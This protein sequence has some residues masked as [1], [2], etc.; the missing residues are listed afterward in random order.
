VVVNSELRLRPPKR[1]PPDTGG[2]QTLQ[3]IT[4]EESDL[5]K[6]TIVMDSIGPSQSIGGID[7]LKLEKQ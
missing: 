5:K 2:W 4:K 6:G 7:Y 3:V 1:R